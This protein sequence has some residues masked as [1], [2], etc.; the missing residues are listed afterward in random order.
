MV[1]KVLDS[2]LEEDV[3]VSQH[4]EDYPVFCFFWGGGLHHKNSLY[5]FS[6]KTRDNG[7]ILIFLEMFLW[8]S[9]L[10]CQHDYSTAACTIY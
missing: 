2:V 4:T 9:L 6:S 1:R 10:H 8:L 7:N 3:I 5:T